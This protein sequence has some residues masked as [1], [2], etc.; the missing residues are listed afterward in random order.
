[1]FQNFTIPMAWIGEGLLY[2]AL[3]SGFGGLSSVRKYTIP[4][5][6]A[7]LVGSLGLLIYAHII[8][9][10]HFL[11]V[12]QHNHTTQPIF[13]RIAGVWG[14]HEGSMLLWV[15]LLGL[16][17]TIT[18]YRLPVPFNQ[19]TTSLIGCLLIV[20][21]VFILIAS[22]PFLT[23]ET[24][25][26]QGE[27]LNPVLQDPSLSIHPPCLYAGYTGLV[28][29]F[30]LAL[31]ALL[32]KEL[33]AVE[34]QALRRWTL[35]A[36]TWLTLGVGLGSFWAYYEL[37]WGGW[38]FWDPVETVSLLPWLV[39]T[40]LLHT[41]RSHPKHLTRTSLLLALLGFSFCLFVLFFVRSGLVA[42]VHS[43]AMDTQRG[44][45]LAIVFSVVT[46]V[47]LTTLMLRSRFFVHQTPHNS[48]SKIMVGSLPLGGLVITSILLAA[49]YPLVLWGFGKEVSIRPEYFHSTFILPA[50]FLIFLMGLGPWLK[51][52][53]DFNLSR[54][55][56]HLAPAFTITLGA[57]LLM[58]LSFNSMPVLGQLS[59]AASLWVIISHLFW[60]FKKGMTFKKMGM[61][62]AHLG[63]ATAILGMVIASYE[64]HQ[65]TMSL[66]RHQEVCL[67][68]GG[69]ITL[70]Q[71]DTILYPTYFAR[72]ASL[73][74]KKSPERSGISFTPERRYYP[75]FNLVH[76]EISFHSFFLS[77]L[78]VVLLD[79]E[80][81]P[82]VFQITEYPFLNFLWLG[83]ILMVAGGIVAY[84]KRRRPFSQT[85]M[86]S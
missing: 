46:A 23:L 45:L 47:S 81:E 27:G 55:S 71:M 25:P 9:D 80:K 41:L 42:S 58:F 11:N 67:K 56:R 76:S 33:S 4:L 31:Q 82:Y 38:W 78:Y 26:S 85:Q 74:F 86:K 28:I 75:D 17:Y 35:L 68:M 37:G 79:D 30:A 29:P 44:L 61:M 21:V 72:K 10:F 84:F 53:E 39:S 14:N 54:L 2:L 50:I 13:Y 1:M 60:F 69:Q 49:I 65:E 32:Q 52:T 48:F 59:F 62:L 15:V 51:K 40:I 7:F 57:T 5:T 8:C 43:F 22:N 36:W 64:Q 34:V 70:E 63:L 12:V 18:W 3:V 83:S 77:H 16:Y 6:T 24:P 19:T 66:A 20:L 73:T